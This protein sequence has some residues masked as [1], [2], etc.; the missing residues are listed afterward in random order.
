MQKCFAEQIEGKDVVRDTRSLLKLMV[1]R[2]LAIKYSVTG[3]DPRRQRT[4]LIFKD[5]ACC[6]FIEG[7]WKDLVIFKFGIIRL[8]TVYLQVAKSTSNVT[9]AI[10]ATRS[11]AFF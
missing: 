8:L 5:T 1:S 2:E 3:M 4:K 9:S 11:V 10:L 6:R 7:E